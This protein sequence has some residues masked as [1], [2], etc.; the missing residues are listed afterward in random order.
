MLPII[1]SHQIGKMCNVVDVIEA[2]VEQV[3]GLHKVAGLSW[4][5]PYRDP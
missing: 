1:P 2:T 3:F 4:P 5:L